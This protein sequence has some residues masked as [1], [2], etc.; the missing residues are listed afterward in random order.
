MILDGRHWIAIETFC[1]R[2]GGIHE[3]ILSYCHICSY[4]FIYVHICSTHFH[5]TSL[6]D[7]MFPQGLQTILWRSAGCQPTPRRKWALAARRTGWCDQ[8]D[9]WQGERF[10]TSTNRIFDDL[11]L[12]RRPPF[13]RDWLVWFWMYC[14]RLLFFGSFPTGKSLIVLVVCNLVTYLMIFAR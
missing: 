2:M 14:P 8:C 6:A 5:E 9:P 10:R 3:H 13:F 12:V 7:V 4:M 11:C 1:N